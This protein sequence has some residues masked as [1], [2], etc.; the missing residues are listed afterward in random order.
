MINKYAKI[1]EN[2]IVENIILSEES[3][4]STLNGLFIK[5]EEKHITACGPQIGDEYYPLK[6][7]FKE[8]QWWDSWTWDEELWKYIPP[9]PKP[10]GPHFWH[11]ENWEPIVTE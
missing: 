7:K 3:Q 11:N 1:D 9:I 6:D 4:I 8:K 10:S 2:N 5:I